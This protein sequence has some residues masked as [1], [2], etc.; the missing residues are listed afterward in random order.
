MRS[1]RIGLI[2]VLVIMA[3]LLG[4]L[5]A[6]LPARAG[7]PHPSA[8][9][10]TTIWHSLVN[11][12]PMHRI[13]VHKG[14]SHGSDAARSD[15]TIGASHS[16][17]PSAESIERGLLERDSPISFR[18]RPT[19]TATPGATPTRPVAP[20]GGGTSF[21]T[22]SGR[23][24]S[25]RGQTVSLRG[26]NFNN[27]PALACCGGPDINK[28]NV[29]KTEYSVLSSWGGNSVRFGLDYNWYSANRGQFFNV[30]DQHVAY[31]KQNHLWMILNL[32]IPPGGASGG[33]EQYALWGQ[34]GN[35]QAL[36]NFWADV[37]VHYANEPTVAGYDLLNEPAPGSDS[38][39]QSLA[40]RIRDA[41]ATKDPNHF[42][43]Y[44]APL[45]NNLMPLSG[46]NIVYSVHHYPG[47]DNYPNGQPSNTPLWVGE[48]GDQSTHGDAVSF[49][50]SEIARYKADGVH[51]SEFVM[52]EGPNDFG[53]YSCGGAGDL[54]CPWNE[55]IAVV[56]N[57]LGGSI[58]P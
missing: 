17:S 26:V 34:S 41:V 47:G 28:I 13:V 30:V 24:F 2:T 37:A 52:R 9:I 31:A 25:Y 5:S 32:F 18:R 14:R 53:L 3:Y 4:V 57:G 23:S 58:R 45:S 50:R 36:V 43:I 48:F 8:A 49:V 1:T 56:K 16:P 6:P 42:V 22:I 10:V 20:P 35:H 19:P 44:E 12:L 7:A 27:E 11:R 15:L 29:N 55:M 54:S 51:W 39:W 40:Q 46:R 21:L 33:F 38:E